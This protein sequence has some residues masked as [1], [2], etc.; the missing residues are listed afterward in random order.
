[1]H[2]RLEEAACLPT[3]GG[4]VPQ[5]RGSWSPTVL[6]EPLGS[7]A[8]LLFLMPAAEKPSHG[9]PQASLGVRAFIKDAFYKHILC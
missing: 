2:V 1:M 5:A 6:A 4:C 9:T 3:P 8:P 7:A